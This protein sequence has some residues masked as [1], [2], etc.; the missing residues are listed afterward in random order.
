MKLPAISL[1]ASLGLLAAP[2]P[3]AAA[4]ACA[5]S[6]PF[7]IA[8]RP[9]P[10]A[11]GVAAILPPKVGRFTRE[12]IPAGAAV[13]ADEDFNVTYQSG[14]DSI[15]IGLSRPGSTADLK[16]A[17]RTSREDAVSDSRIDRTGEL[18]C[19]TSAPFFYKIPDFIAWTRGPY[20]FYA[21]AS[22]PAILAEFMKAFP[23]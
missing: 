9:E 6:I 21:D 14:K 3:A 4:T 17:V 18:Y 13:P 12:V 7:G 1:I 2:A 16:E 5:K 8:A 11:A 23:Y 22:S 19:V 20:F 10:S 15:F